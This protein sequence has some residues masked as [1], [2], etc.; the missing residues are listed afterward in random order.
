MI[1]RLLLLMLLGFNASVAAA[2]SAA[3]L[4]VASAEAVGMSSERLERLDAFVGDLI[5]RDRL[6]GAVTAIARRGRL[7]HWNAQ[8]MANI[9]GH[10]AMRKDD[11]FAFASMTKPVTAVAVMMLVEE[12]R[13]RLSDPLEKFLPEFRDMKVAV[14]DPHAPEGY[15]LEPAKRSITI[16][17]L[18]THRSGFVGPPASRS[19]AAMLERKIAQG[20]PKN[21]TLAQYVSG[22][23]QAPLDN[24]PGAAWEYGASFAVLGRVIE[25]VSGQSFPEFIR[26]RLFDPLHMVD[27]GFVVPEQQRSR[28][29]TLYQP[30]P[31]GGLQARAPSFGDGSFPSGSG[32]L[33]STA[34]DYLRFCQMLLNGGELDG[35]RVLSRKSIEL[36][37]SPRVAAIPLPFLPGQGYGLGV[38]VQQPGGEAGLLGSP[39]TYGWSGAYN[40]YFRIDPHEQLI[41]LLLVQLSPA[42][43]LEIQ[44]GFQNV[45]M[46]AIVD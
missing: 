38:A 27:S 36:M 16:H 26:H 4:P 28:V 33:F 39:G 44:Y 13:L 6:A 22:V 46:Q 9:A 42:N 19:P 15:V 24:Q 23:A 35:S 10:R 32:G 30:Q 43:D 25:V 11:I 40:T 37:A 17:D 5:Q 3:P 20:W 34:S 8:G 14:A 12:G 45:A 1:M 31:G 18:L 29:V 7:V 21:P 2:E 41:V